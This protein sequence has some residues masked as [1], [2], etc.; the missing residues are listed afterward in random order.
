MMSD[1]P[2]I[3]LAAWRLQLTSVLL[4]I[5]AAVQLCG[6]PPD[7]RHRVLQSVSLRGLVGGAA[8]AAA[9]AACC[10]AGVCL[11]V[12]HALPTAGRTST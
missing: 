10:P 1:V 9:A 6:M 8:T 12:A 2:P 11:T 3:T 7:D 4:G 5:G